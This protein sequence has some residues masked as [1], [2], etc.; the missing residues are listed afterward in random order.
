MEA[1][2]RVEEFKSAIARA[3]ILYIVN[4]SRFYSFVR[5]WLHFLRFERLD[6]LLFTRTLKVSTRY[7]DT[8]RTYKLFLMRIWRSGIIS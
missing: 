6:R 3:V 2:N 8:L 7:R 5:R 4:A 1:L